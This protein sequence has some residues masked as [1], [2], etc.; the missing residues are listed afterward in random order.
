MRHITRS[1]TINTSKEEVWDVLF[2]QFGDVNNW[3]PLI[4][5][6]SFIKGD[7]GAIGCERMCTIDSKSKVRERII[8]S[9]DG[10]SFDVEVF[11]G[12]L[13]M[14]DKMKGRFDLVEISGERTK[15]L[16]TMYFTTK[17][18]FIG[19]IMKGKMSNFFFK[20]LVGLKYHLETGELITKENIK[21]IEGLYKG[22][23][24]NDS[25]SASVAVAS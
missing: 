24:E 1:I 3:N 6:S 15:V 21:E 7:T 4:E 16:F 12:G 25:F 20:M 13:P 8:R 22:L 17:P 18:A 19:A 11:D 5:G 10:Q 2:N 23:N 14:M 9:E